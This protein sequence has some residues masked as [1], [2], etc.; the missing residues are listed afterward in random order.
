MSRKKKDIP[1]KPS[2]FGLLRPYKRMIFLLVVF[3]L[4][5]NAVNL[6][7]PKIISH[8]IDDYTKGHFFIKTIIIEFLGSALIIFLFT[9]LQSILQTYASER[10]ARDIRTQLSTK[11][12]QQNYSYIIKANPS[13]LLT[14]LTSDVD[15]IKM[16]V[17]QAIVSIVSSIF[18]IIGASILLISI[19][20]RLA[21]PVLSIIP[22]I[23]GGF[24]IVF[25]KVRVL[26]K[27]SREVI[28]WLIKVINERILGS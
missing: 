8:G 26:F 21:L 11:I 9:Y 7:I 14:N 16:F 25:R 2:V 1:S 17:A 13:K 10:V 15:S 4:I 3:A 6:L 23:G 18:I 24:F 20:W 19:N 22:I 5:S 12:S 27:K 28:D